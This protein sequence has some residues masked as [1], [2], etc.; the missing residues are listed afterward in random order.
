VE[1]A[2]QYSVV[3]NPLVDLAAVGAFGWGAYLLGRMLVRREV[4]IRDD[5]A[6][7]SWERAADFRGCYVYG[8]ILAAFLMGMSALLIYADLTGYLR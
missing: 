7:W 6:K 5:W 4:L 8:L 3:K 2:R 1:E